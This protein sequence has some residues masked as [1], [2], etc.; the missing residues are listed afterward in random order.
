MR[1]ARLFVGGGVDAG[2]DCAADSA[3]MLPR[4]LFGCTRDSLDDESFL[5]GCCCVD[6]LLALDGGAADFA[7]G[8]VGFGVARRESFEPPSS[9]SSA[10]IFMFCWSSAGSVKAVSSLGK[11]SG[12]R[13][14]RAF[15]LYMVLRCFHICSLVILRFIDLLN[16]STMQTMKKC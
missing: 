13:S 6:S 11:G 16:R 10:L 7:T 12:S 2:L 4:V 1:R 15:R 5:R 9:D 14:S 3:D 8:A